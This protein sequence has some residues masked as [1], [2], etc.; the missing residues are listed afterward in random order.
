MKININFNKSKTQQ[1]RK[2]YS[3]LETWYTYK[4]KKRAKHFDNFGSCSVKRDS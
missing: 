2:I 4:N 3:P 1:A